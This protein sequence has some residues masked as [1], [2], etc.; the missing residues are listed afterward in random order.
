MGG[1][2]HLVRKNLGRKKLRTL[3]TLLSVVIAFI[4]FALLG[5][6]N[7]AFTA[8]VELAGADRLVTMHK[9]SFIQ[10]MPISYVA[11]VEGMDGV[12]AATHYTWFG[13]Y[14]QDPKQQFGL[15][16]TNLEKLSDIYPEYEM[17]PDQREHLMETRTGLLVGRAMAD[18]YGWEAGD[19]VPI[20]S[21]IYPKRD[22]SYAWEFE[23]AAIFTGTGNTA[24]EM[25]A[26][27]HYD[28]FNEARQFGQDMIGWIVTR[29]EDPELADTVSGAIDARF[30]NSPTETKTSTEAG[31]AAS[32]AAQFGNIGLIVQMILG[33]VFFTLL[34]ISGNT[35]AQA[36]R[37]RTGELA[38]LKTI[39]FSDARVTGMVLAESLLVAVVGGVIG[40]LIGGLFVTGAASA[41]AQF[42]PGLAMSSGTLLW[43]LMLA[44]A[45]GLVTGAWPAWRAARLDVIDAMGRR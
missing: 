43:G 42:F 1:M 33:C 14:F 27:M 37:E 8:G 40:L 12:R 13:G 28:Y 31:F 6:L 22:G 45:L 24:D 2:F 20:F 10:L 34:L 21:S 38:V 5:G 7:R 17:P 23:I 44:V 39:G 9:V 15:F 29:I 41:L 26:F 35:M 32:F 18:L 4:L 36:V 25:Q 30:A 11:R 3:F 19:Q 16:P